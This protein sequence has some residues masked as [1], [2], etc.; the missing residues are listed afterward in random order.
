MEERQGGCMSGGR[1][2]KQPVRDVSVG[3]Q[4]SHMSYAA[5]ASG[6]SPFLSSD[7]PQNQEPRV[8]L[9]PSAGV[10]EGGVRCSETFK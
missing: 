3:K 2:S 9:E 1:E 5:A 10:A 8:G 6:L 7:H 4:T